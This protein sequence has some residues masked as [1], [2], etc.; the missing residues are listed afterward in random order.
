[1]GL[2]AWVRVTAA[3]RHSWLGLSGCGCLCARS[4]RTLP[5]LFWGLW[6]KRLWFGFRL[7][8]RLPK[9]GCWRYCV[10]VCAPPVLRHSWLGCVVWVCA[11]GRVFA[12]PRHSWLGCWG[13]CV[14][15]RSL[16]AAP[17]SWLGFVV[18]GL[19]VARYLSVGSVPLWVASS[20]LRGASRFVLSGR[21]WCSGRLC[22]RRGG[23]F[24]RGFRPRIYWAAARGTWRRAKNWTHGAC[25]LPRPR[26]AAWARSAT[27]PFRAPLW[28]CPWRVPPASVLGY[29]RCDGSMYVDPDTHTSRFPYRQSSDGGLCRCTGAVM[30]GRRHCYFGVG[31][32]HAP[33][34]CVCA[35]AW[36]RQPGRAGRPLGRNLVRLTFHLAVLSSCLARPPPGWGCPFPV[37]LFAQF[38]SLCLFSFFPSLPATLLTPAFC[39]FRPWLPLAL[40]LVF[41]QTPP[42]RPG[43]LFCFHCLARPRCLRLS[44]VSDP[45]CRGPWRCAVPPPFFFLLH[46]CLALWASAPLAC[47]LFPPPHSFS[48]FFPFFFLAVCGFLPPPPPR[49]FFCRSPCAPAAFVFSASPLAAPLRLLPPSAAPPPPPGVCFLRGSSPGGSVLRSFP[50]LFCSC[51][52]AWRSWAVVADC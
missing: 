10:C 29:L 49:C 4:N 31:G 1:M 32:R 43:R 39:G 42:P 41:F 11:W 20:H 52:L 18:S 45:E 14:G 37:L 5:I 26:H 36:F 33:V 16:P 8:P 38:F 24:Y 48:S 13:V 46:P 28:G 23:F 19:G 44:L 35:C 9:L 34:P 6:C 17:Q 2:C 21:S 30:C 27:Y 12:A 51:L 50:L 40:A 3:P 22:R 47:C 15:V 7:S 25:R